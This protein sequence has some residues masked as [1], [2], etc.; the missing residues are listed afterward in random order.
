M[1]IAE[2]VAN[3]REQINEACKRVNRNPEEI[4][5]I[6]V[7][8]YTNVARAKE[9]LQAGIVHLGE[10]RDKGFLEKY[11]A[12]GDQ[13]VWHFIGT[14]QSR[15]VKNVIH[16]IDYLHSL[17]RLSLAKEIEKRA[18][19]PVRCFVQVN[20]SNE[21]SKHGLKPEEVLPFIDELQNYKKIHVVG[22]M[23]MAPHTDDETVIRQAFRDL[24]QI[25]IDVQ[26]KGYEYAPCS[27]L[28]M[29]M[30]NDFPIA[31]EEGATMIRIGRK[32]VGD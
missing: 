20:T 10:N 25:Q 26:K 18:E 9:L 15:K 16:F 7:T 22:L 27:E 32:L 12:L 28:S 2:N 17:D 3:I 4:T 21:A 30:S 8:K 29:G 6:A 24:K 5:L 31:I 19:R 11:E 13:P 23:T 1:T 14:L